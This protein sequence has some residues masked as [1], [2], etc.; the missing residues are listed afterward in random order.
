MLKKKHIV[1]IVSIAVIAFL[2]GTMINFNLLTIAGKE[3][4]DGPPTWQAYVTGVN[5]SA[6]PDVWR[7]NATNLAFDEE[8]NLRVTQMNE[9]QSSIIIVFNQTLHACENAKVSYKT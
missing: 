8:G 7:V 9:E 5:A 2:I 4:E 1:E 3:E 6:L